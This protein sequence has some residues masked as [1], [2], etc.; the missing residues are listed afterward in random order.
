MFLLNVWITYMDFEV[1]NPRK[2]WCFSAVGIPGRERSLSYHQRT[3]DHIFRLWNLHDF[4]NSRR[5]VG[6]DTIRTQ[7]GLGQLWYDEVERHGVGGVRGKW[8]AGVILDQLFGVAVICCDEQSAAH[9]QG[10]LNDAP[11]ACIDRLDRLDGSIDHPGVADHVRVG[12]VHNDQV[13]LPAADAFDGGIGD[14]CRA[15]LWLQIVGW[16]F[17][18][19]HQYAVF[20]RKR[21]FAPPVDE[22]SDVS[23]LLGLGGVKLPQ[24]VFGDDAR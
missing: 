23:V 9:S 1:K 15:H 16:H 24:A 2:T 4:Q 12:V 8:F 5:H 11:D 19:W 20:S 22:V 17:G 3:P 13:V 7:P 14:A 18:G 10:C 21:R 6:K